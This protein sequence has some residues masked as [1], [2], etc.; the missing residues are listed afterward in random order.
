[1]FARLLDRRRE[2]DEIVFGEAMRGRAHFH[3]ARLA[4]GERPGFVDDDCG[5]FFE[6]LDG[7]GIFDQHTG[8]RAATDAHHDRHGR[9]QAKR[10]RARDNQHGDGVDDGV[11]HARLRTQPQPCGEGQRGTGQHRRDK[12]T[13]HAVGERLDRRA[14]ALRVGHHLHD[15]GQHRL[16]A[17]ALGTHDETTGA[18]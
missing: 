1:M 7:F 4:F 6:A 11:G 18:H 10:A 14:A 3:E 17:D 16:A 15:A 9:R 8:T 12:V 5:D 2:R 13:G